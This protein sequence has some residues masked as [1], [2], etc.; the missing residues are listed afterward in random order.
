MTD[1][2]LYEILREMWENVDKKDAKAVYN[3]LR[4]RREILKDKEIG[5][6]VLEKF[7]HR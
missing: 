6:Q 2:E 3:F 4:L 1:K 5:K 7:Y